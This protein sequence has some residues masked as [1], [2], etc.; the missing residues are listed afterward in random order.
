MTSATSEETKTEGREYQG[1]IA[2]QVRVTA[3]SEWEAR[4]KIAGLQQYLKDHGITIDQWSVPLMRDMQATPED[5]WVDKY[6]VLAVIDVATSNYSTADCAANEL[7]GLAVERDTDLD[8]TARRVEA[9]AR[10]AT[11]AVSAAE[12]L[13]RSRQATADRLQKRVTEVA[14]ERRNRMTQGVVT[15][16]RLVSHVPNPTPPSA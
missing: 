7:V 13:L 3:E 5:A 15:G 11:E 8:R 6:S 10:E 1:T 14:E 12:E 2:S 16:Y 4:E 9:E